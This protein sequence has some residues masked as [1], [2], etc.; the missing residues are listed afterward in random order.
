[1]PG[2]LRFEKPGEEVA[3][4]RDQIFSEIKNLAT[5]GP[6]E[7]EMEKLRNSLSND[8]VRGRQSSMYRAQRIAEYALYDGDPQL[9][10]TELSIYLAV[11]AAEIKSA[12]SEFSI[13]NRAYS[14]IPAPF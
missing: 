2:N 11:T 7:E 5:E 9:F 3:S 8:A 10:D 4:I 6:S 1:M 12:G 13:E 14:H